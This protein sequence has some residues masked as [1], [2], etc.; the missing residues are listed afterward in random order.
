MLSAADGRRTIGSLAAACD[1]SHRHLIS[2]FQK[3]IGVAPK[4]AARLLRF[5]R[6][7]RLMNRRAF[8]RRDPLA[9]KPYI[10][11]PTADGAAVPEI[12]WAGIAADC[13]YFDQSHFIREFR[14]FAGATPSAFLQQVTDVD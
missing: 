7:V 14:Q 9:G 13:G 2:Q 11:T 6:A 8:A 4:S 10:E 5:N 1:C 3:C 12:A